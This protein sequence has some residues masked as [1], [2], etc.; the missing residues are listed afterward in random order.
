MLTAILIFLPLLASVLVLALKPAQ[1][2]VA[3]LVI[4]LAELA[5]SIVA[6]AQFSPA[7]TSAFSIATPWIAQLGINF[8]IGMDGTG[9]VLVL[10]ATVLTPLIILSSFT[11][12]TERPALFYFLILVMQAAMIG[13]FV[14]EDGFLF[15]IFWEMALIPIYFICLLWGG[16]QRVRVTLKFFIY[17]LAGSLFMLI[18]LI[19]LYL[20][21]PGEH[22]FAMQ[23]LYEA[24]NNLDAV[25]QSW[26]FWALFVA[27]AI[28]MPVFPFH[29]WQPDT[30]FEAPAQ[31][32]MLLSGIMLKMG[33]F[34][35]IRWLL[36]VV[37]QG[38]AQWS[39]VAV[40]LSVIGVV[41]A[42]FL[43]I[44]Q[45]DIKRLVAYSSIAH[46]GLI[47]AGIF[48]QNTA[49]VQGAV[50][51]M[52]SHG[53]IVFGLFYMVEIIQ[54]RTGTTQIDELGGIRSVA[55]KLATLFMV[56]MFGSV[57]LPFT[58]GFVGEFLL[59]NGIFQ[60]QPWL[61]AV[62]GL[63]VILGAIYMLNA[64]RKS[65]S[66][67]ANALTQNITD[68]TG[69]EKAVLIPLCLLIVVIGIYPAPLLDLSQ[70][71]AQNLLQIVELYK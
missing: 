16:A 32:T 28:K 41:Y 20:Q 26:V 11:G 30:Y 47:S 68:L 33:V 21:T 12:T 31:G 53:I 10:L 17:T 36:P 62:A 8:N 15:Y 18:G 6:F 49:A 1:A 19:Y 71:A 34:G 56:I 22:S 37:P 60:Y 57:A 4:A 44:I 64:Y 5:V 65:T 39:Y 24:G 7:D 63:S 40:I 38:V 43:A 58:S 27:F 35:V 46:V 13:V 66:G 50:I 48:T 67:E 45:K 51:Q 2:R 61:S 59:L 70:T 42:S 23:A 69:V 55:P 25:S 14:A 54:T 29:T 52:F 3:A 9:L